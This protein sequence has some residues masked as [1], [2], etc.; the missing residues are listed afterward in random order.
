MQIN[1]AIESH[2]SRRACLARLLVASSAQ[3][4]DDT[5]KPVWHKSDL[6][7]GPVVYDKRPMAVAHALH[8]SG[9]AVAC[10]KNHILSEYRLVA[11]LCVGIVDVSI[12]DDVPLILAGSALLRF[13]GT[14][15]CGS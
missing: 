5:N 3:R 11:L 2:N 10:Y 1:A 13:T 8:Q 4:D 9:T 6:R 12:S 7:D 14:M 15:H